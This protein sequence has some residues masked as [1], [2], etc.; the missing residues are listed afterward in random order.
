MVVAAAAA[1]MNGASQRICTFPKALSGLPCWNVRF[2]GQSKLNW[3]YLSKCPEA[4]EKMT[5][6]ISKSTN[7]QGAEFNNYFTLEQSEK[8][9]NAPKGGGGGAKPNYSLEQE[10]MKDGLIIAMMGL[11]R[12]AFLGADGHSAPCDSANLLKYGSAI[13]KMIRDAK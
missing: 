1:V 12:G 5:I 3:M 6:V 4:G 7:A 8:I 9:K 13:A 10:S 11:S 2:E